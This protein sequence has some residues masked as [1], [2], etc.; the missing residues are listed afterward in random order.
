MLNKIVKLSQK[1]TQFS[2]T[3]A[4]ISRGGGLAC[5]TSK[6][7]EANYALFFII[8]SKAAHAVPQSCITHSEKNKIYYFL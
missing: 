4:S 2:H 5:A 6:T 3:P 8:F 1:W 7:H